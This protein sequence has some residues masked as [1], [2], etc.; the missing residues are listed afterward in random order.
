MSERRKKDELAPGSR[1]GSDR[2]VI[3]R[4]SNSRVA[5]DFRYIQMWVRG[6]AF[7][8]LA[9]AIGKLAAGL[10]SVEPMLMVYEAFFAVFMLIFAILLLKYAH[11]IGHYLKNESVTN[12]EASVERQFEFWQSTGIF[13]F[14]FVVVNVIYSFV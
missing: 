5:R 7:M 6:M 14:I 8:I 11:A 1:S 2:R 3:E 13:V 10:A 9:G 12:L 4:F